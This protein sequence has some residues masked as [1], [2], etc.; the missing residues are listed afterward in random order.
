MPFPRV[1]GINAGG[2]PS[3][4]DKT[5]VAENF[6]FSDASPKKVFTIPAGY[7]IITCQII[8]NT[9][10]DD[11]TTTLKVGTLALD[12][13]YMADTANSPTESGEYETNPY[14]A[15][16]V[17]TDIYLTLAPGASTQGAGVVQLELSQPLP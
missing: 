4:P 3:T 13:K 8:I 15:V 11:A 1:Y 14:Q 5:W 7:S 9:V 10:F 12:N 17:D 6:L 16:L 2:G